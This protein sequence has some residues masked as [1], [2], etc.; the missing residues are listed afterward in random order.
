MVEM[1]EGMV[2]SGA[3]D[4]GKAGM[5]RRGGRVLCPHGGV[6]YMDIPQGQNSLSSTLRSR[7]WLTP[8]FISPSREKARKKYRAPVDGKQAAELR[9]DV[10]YLQLTLKYIKCKMMDGGKQG[11]VQRQ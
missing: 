5:L 9:D 1:P 7:H 10:C 6:G 11:G 8:N 3:A 2:A 4:Q